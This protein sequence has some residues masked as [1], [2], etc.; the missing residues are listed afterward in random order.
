MYNRVK[1]MVSI[2]GH[3]SNVGVHQGEKLSPLLLS[4]YIKDVFILF[5][6]T[7]QL[8]FQSLQKVCNMLLRYSMYNRGIFT[9]F[10]LTLQSNTAYKISLK[11]NNNQPLGLNDM[12]GHCLFINIC[13]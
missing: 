5:L 10:Q 2:N 11:E 9:R 8:L 4:M 12:N 7:I 3:S 1:S 13:C 6:L